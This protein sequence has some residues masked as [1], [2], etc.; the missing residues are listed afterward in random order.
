MSNPATGRRRTLEFVTPQADDFLRAVRAVD[1]G[2][3]RNIQ[4]LESGELGRETHAALDAAREQWPV[5][6]AASVDAITRGG[7]VILTETDPDKLSDQLLQFADQDDVHIIAPRTAR[8]F[9]AQPLFLVTIPKSGTHLLRA[10]L[11]AFGYGE[12]NDH[13]YTPEPGTWYCLEFSNTHT[14]AT[15]FFVDGV[16]RAPFGNRHHPFPR[17]PALFLYRNPLDILVSEAMYYQHD[18]KTLFAGYLSGLELEQRIARLIRDPWLLG[19]LRDRMSGFIPWLGFANV[20][21][22]SFEELV[23]DA[24]GGS[25]ELQE[26]VVWSLQLKLHIPGAPA[27]YAARA[28]DRSAPTFASG[29]IGLHRETLSDAHRAGLRELGQDYMEEFGFP[30]GGAGSNPWLPGRMDEFRHRPLRLAPASTGLMPV[31][32]EPDQMFFNIV[33]FDGRY[34]GVPCDLGPVDVAA[35]ADPQRACLP[36]NVSLPRLRAQ[37]ALGPEHAGVISDWYSLVIAEAIRSPVAPLRRIRHPLGRLMRLIDIYE[38][39]RVRLR[40]LFP[41]AK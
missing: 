36:S 9:R 30:A 6:P 12:G 24:G 23:G 40:R 33:Y 28:Y 2:A 5:Q 31:L 13:N 22:V 32:V 14:R 19:S 21:P 26:R 3:A 4:L 15:D 18:G 17:T 16:R 35:L 25:R 1:P 29:R 11:R 27:D 41:A 38:K 20:I 7:M 37:L 10:L 8:H 34:Y 39:L